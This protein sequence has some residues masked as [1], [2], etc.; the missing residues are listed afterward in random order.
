MSGRCW[1][2]CSALLVWTDAAQHVLMLQI[3]LWGASIVAA[4]ALGE[5][6][7]LGPRLLGQCWPPQRR[8]TPKAGSSR[9]APGGTVS[10]PCQKM[11]SDTGGDTR[12]AAAIEAWLSAVGRAACTGALTA[13]QK[14]GWEQRLMQRDHLGGRGQNE[15]QQSRQESPDGGRLA[16]QLCRRP[17][18]LRLAAGQT[19]VPCR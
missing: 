16:V 6:T 5:G 11:C 19:L 17:V 12:Q 2:S 3:M 13:V 1:A 10:V 18:T 14:P 7:H 15:Q 9:C 4:Q 8:R